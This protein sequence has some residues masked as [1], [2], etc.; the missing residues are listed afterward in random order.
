MAG[1]FFPPAVLGGMVVKGLGIGESY[2]LIIA[3]DGQRT[4]NVRELCEALTGATRGEL[5][6]LVVVR[7]G[8]RNNIE[9]A[10]P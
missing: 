10:L 1:M 4:H 3:V 2:D 8:R 7:G 6:Y 5:L 9:V